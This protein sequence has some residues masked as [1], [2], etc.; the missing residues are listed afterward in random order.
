MV[1]RGH[2][3]AVAPD[4]TVF[5]EF[6]KVKNLYAAKLGIGDRCELETFVGSHTINGK[7]T[8][9]FLHKHLDWPKPPSTVR[10]PKPCAI[11]PRLAISCQIGRTSI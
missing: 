2:F 11:L 1:E 10:A 3:D 5:Y 6:G 8:F 9:D 7:G 4:E